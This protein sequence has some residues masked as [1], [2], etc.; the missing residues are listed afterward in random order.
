MA[1]ASGSPRL[2]RFRNLPLL[3]F[4]PWLLLQLFPIGSPWVGGAPCSPGPPLFFSRLLRLSVF[5]WLLEV[6]R[7]L[8]SRPAVSS[9]P[10]RLSAAVLSV[11][12]FPLSPN[13][14]HSSTTLRICCGAALNMRG[15]VWAPQ[16]VGPDST[17]AS[18]PCPRPSVPPLPHVSTGAGLLSLPTVGIFAHPHN[19]PQARSSGSGRLGFTGCSEQI[20]TVNSLWRCGGPG[21]SVGATF[22]LLERVG[23]CPI[24]SGG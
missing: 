12:N 13:S 17:S 2:C 7:I 9:D 24:L 16:T 19:V 21:T 22:G 20:L 5:F 14:S 1:E 6:R 3:F 23:R 8:H 15:S 11:Q 4:S 10:I 18:C